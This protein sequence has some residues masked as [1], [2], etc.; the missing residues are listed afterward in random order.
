[1][2]WYK[3]GVVQAPHW[4]CSSSLFTLSLTSGWQYAFAFIT[5]L[6]ITSRISNLVLQNNPSLPKI[7]SLLYF[8][9]NRALTP[10]LQEIHVSI[11]PS[12]FILPSFLLTLTPWFWG[13]PLPQADAGGW[14]CLDQRS[15]GSAPP[16]RLP[17]QRK[18]R[19]SG[20]QLDPLSPGQ[21]GRNYLLT[22]DVFIRPGKKKQ[23]VSRGTVK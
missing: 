1:M 19:Y 15:V 21:M 5:A 3:E 2:G 14:A 12:S 23:K 8:H 18:K 16:Q 9:S 6:E 10:L 4:C 13:A 17:E 22:Y 7:L 20:C 11:P